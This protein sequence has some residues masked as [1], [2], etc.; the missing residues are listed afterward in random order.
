MKI[1]VELVLSEQE[2]RRRAYRVQVSKQVQMMLAGE[3]LELLDLSEIGVAFKTEQHLDGDLEEVQILF[4]LDRPQRIKAQ[5]RVTFCARG[6]CGAEF[7]G[8][9]EREHLLLSALVVKLQKDQ[10]RQERALRQQDDG[11]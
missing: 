10:I 11:A 1:P 9:N 6:R 2:N 4:T 3:P 7:V 5:L 8:L